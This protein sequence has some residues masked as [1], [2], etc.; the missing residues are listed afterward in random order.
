MSTATHIPARSHGGAPCAA[1]PVR[2]VVL[3]ALVI[4]AAALLALA[5]AARAEPAGAPGTS[6]AL[7]FVDLGPAHACAVERG[8]DVRCWGRGASGALGS[9]TLGDRLAGAGSAASTVAL[10]AA[11]QVATG[12]LHTCVILV[13]GGVRCWGQGASGQLGSRDRDNRLD[14]YADPRT[15]TD[16]ASTVPLGEAATQLSAGGG[17]TCAVVTSGAVRCWGDGLFGRTGARGTDNR[18]DGLAD[19]PNDEATTVP[20]PGP[21]SAVSAGDQHACALLTS[22]AVHCWG[23]GA[24]GRLGSGRQDDRLDGVVDAESGTDDVSTV[25]LGGPAT[26]ITAGGGHTCALLTTG[27]VR[28]W[29]LGTSGQLGQ[30]RDNESVLDSASEQPTTVPLKPIG[31]AANR[32]ATTPN[33][34]AIAISAGDFHT[35]AIVEGGDVRC[36]GQG[37]SGQLG[38]GAADGRLDTSPT[39]PADAAS[40]VG[41]GVDGRGSGLG[42]PAVAITSGASSTCAALATG[43]VRCWGA[44]DGGRLGSG[45]EDARLDGI[46]DAATRTDDASVVPIGPLPSSAADGLPAPA[47]PPAAPGTSSRPQSAAPAAPELAFTLRLKGRALTVKALLAPA[48][49]GTCPRRV[50]VSIKRGRSKL[51][52]G[53]LRVQRKGANCR[54]AGKVRLR[55]APKRRVRLTVHLSGTGVVA[56][57]L[58]VTAK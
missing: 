15:G 36:W 44:G 50:G 34:K 24:N 28:C 52:K 25:P 55:Q 4:V 27:D 46:V 11:T 51:A 29:G 37:T 22:G 42:A 7:G 26:A 14:G 1:E 31:T 45:A 13:G 38:Q 18:L 53:T 57:D 54:A 40:R 48:K 23:L 32:V 49:S 9:G 30:G 41:G 3:A 56:R 16:A 8:R 20:L 10:G 33:L 43:A 21:A 39:Q 17:F 5:P 35:C 2:S 19:G 6:N 12:D 58:T 47:T